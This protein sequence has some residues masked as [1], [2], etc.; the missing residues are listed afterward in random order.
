[1]F[2]RRL[3]ILMIGG[4]LFCALA[5]ATLHGIEKAGHWLLAIPFVVALCCVAMGEVLAWHNAACGWHERR[6][7]S[8]LLWGTL[9]CLLTSGV[10][11]TNFSVGAGNNDGKHAVQLTAMT[12]QGDVGA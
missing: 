7:G 1:T 4:A 9:G 2:S 11:Y 6:I 10:I 5:L 12:T 8:M 3:T